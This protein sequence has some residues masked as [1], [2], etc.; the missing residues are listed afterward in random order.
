MG[1]TTIQKWVDLKHCEVQIWL[2][3]PVFVR[4][5]EKN[6]VVLPSVYALPTY[7]SSSVPGAESVLGVRIPLAAKQGNTLN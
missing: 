6:L 2:Y 7:L 4:T 1:S 3:F 5:L